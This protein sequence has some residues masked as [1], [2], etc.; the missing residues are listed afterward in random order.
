MQQGALQENTKLSIY[1]WCYSSKNLRWLPFHWSIFSFLICKRYFG[2]Q[3]QDSKHRGTWRLK[4]RLLTTN[5]QG[6]HYPDEPWILCVF[7][8]AKKDKFAVN[9]HSTKSPLI[10]RASGTPASFIRFLRRKNFHELQN[11]QWLHLLGIFGS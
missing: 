4:N 1:T 10:S 9:C 3:L 11:V 5:R 2:L 8:S 6:G 7:L